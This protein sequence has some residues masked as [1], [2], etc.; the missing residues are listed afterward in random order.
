MPSCKGLIFKMYTI[1]KNNGNGIPSTINC[2]NIFKCVPTLE[3]G[4]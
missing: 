2:S 4:I 1:R 3:V